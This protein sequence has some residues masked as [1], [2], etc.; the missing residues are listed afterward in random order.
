MEDRTC[1]S[2]AVESKAVK[3]SFVGSMTSRALAANR[4]RRRPLQIHLDNAQAVSVF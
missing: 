2:K 4:R 3:R 1:L